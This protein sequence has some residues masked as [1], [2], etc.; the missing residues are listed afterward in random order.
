[1]TTEQDLSLTPSTPKALQRFLDEHTISAEIVTLAEETPTVESSARAMG[2]AVDQI[3]K[4][5]LFLVDKQPL[6]VLAS[7]VRRVCRK[8]LAKHLL[9]GR[10]KVKLA[11]SDAVLRH[12]GFAVGTVPPLGHPSRLPT[13]VEEAVVAQPFL[14]VGGGGINALMRIETSVLLSYLDA[15]VVS[16]LVESS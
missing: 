6:L 13:I 1:M 8:R 11:G 15:P 12:T 7:G 14:Y 5:V 16:L 9:I 4:S 2:V 3:G 10:G